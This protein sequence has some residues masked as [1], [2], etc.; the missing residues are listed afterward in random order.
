MS[1]NKIIALVDDDCNFEELRN[2]LCGYKNSG[3]RDWERTFTND[4]RDGP[5]GKIQNKS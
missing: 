1:F 4:V 2:Q 3:T 5:R